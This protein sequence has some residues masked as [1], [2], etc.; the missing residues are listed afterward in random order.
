M[1]QV[2][3]IAFADDRSMAHAQDI[4]TALK[5]LERDRVTQPP[6]VETSEVAE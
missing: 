4:A 2:P 1:R 3:E 5:E 6:V